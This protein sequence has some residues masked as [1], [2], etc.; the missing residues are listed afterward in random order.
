VSPLRPALPPTCRF[1]RRFRAAPRGKPREGGE[2]RPCLAG[3]A[4]C[5]G[6]LQTIR[7]A[8]RRTTL[9]FCSD[10]DRR[11]DFHVCAG[12]FEPVRDPAAGQ[13]YGT[14]DLTRSPGDP[15][16]VHPHLPSL[17]RPVPVSQLDLNNR[18]RER[19]TSASTR[20]RL[21]LVIGAAP[22]YVRFLLVSILG[23]GS[24]PDRYARNGA[25]GSIH[26]HWPSMILPEFALQLPS[27]PSADR[28]DHA[29]LDCGRARVRSW[30][31]RISGNSRRSVRRTPTTE[32]WPRR[33][34]TACETFD[35]R[36]AGQHS[37]M[38]SSSLRA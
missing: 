20:S 22:D 16:E 19:L 35:R 1:A 18:V 31:L 10:L 38:A 30:H 14:V 32:P 13:V 21:S 24:V 7:T 27:S 6:F 3:A 23:G 25:G 15:D 34:C 26:C 2:A 37:S 5:L 36:R 12:L 29:G 9:Q 33:P 17:G 28:E 4:L 8:E 11:S